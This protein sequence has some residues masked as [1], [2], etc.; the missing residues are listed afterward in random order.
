[1]ISQHGTRS[2]WGANIGDEP[3]VRI[4]VGDRWRVGTATFVPDDDVSARARS[5]SAN[6]LFGRLIGA[7][8]RALQTDPISVRIDFTD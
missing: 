2:G 5:F 4:R 7:G 6:P 8:F 3:R 1:V